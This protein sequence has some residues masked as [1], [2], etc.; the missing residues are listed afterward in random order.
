VS[1]TNHT[2]LVTVASFTL[3]V[4]LSNGMGAHEV[5][6]GMDMTTSTAQKRKNTKE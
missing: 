3:T 5:H 1:G 4:L 6:E 2:I